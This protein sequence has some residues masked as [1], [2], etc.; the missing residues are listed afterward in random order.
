MESKQ[1]ADTCAQGWQD[2]KIRDTDTNRE[3]ETDKIDKIHK[4]E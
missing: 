4:K 3:V 2:N 1:T